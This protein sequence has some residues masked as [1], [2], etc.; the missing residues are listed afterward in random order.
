MTK[1]ER[2]T[3]NGMTMPVTLINELIA[4][5]IDP[6]KW[7]QDRKDEYPSGSLTISGM[8]SRSRT[9]SEGDSTKESKTE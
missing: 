7:V 5:G 1:I 4:K 2:R 3:V 8:P 6:E 9:P